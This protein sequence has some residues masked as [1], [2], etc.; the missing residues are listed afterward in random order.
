MFITSTQEEFVRSLYN[1]SGNF[2]VTEEDR[3]AL[4][5]LVRSVKPA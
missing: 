1:R 4:D 2:E 3:R 5:S